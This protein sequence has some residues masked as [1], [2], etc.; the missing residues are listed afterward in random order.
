ME[1]PIHL[2]PMRPTSILATLC[3]A[4]LFVGLLPSALSVQCTTTFTGESAIA[5]NGKFAPQCAI[6]IFSTLSSCRFLYHP[7]LR[8]SSLS[9]SVCG[10]FRFGPTSLLHLN[11]VLATTALVPPF[12]TLID[13][14]DDSSG[15]ELDANFRFRPQGQTPIIE[16][17]DP[18]PD[19]QVLYEVT[20]FLPLLSRFFPSL[21]S[22]SLSVPA[23]SNHFCTLAHRRHGF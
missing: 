5:V 14:F 7:L 13:D 9:S 12:L 22:L 1:T 2:K 16:I 3:L 11:L 23:I 4:I 19:H 18:N 20:L 10:S 15:C 6:L 8:H 17:I 21:L